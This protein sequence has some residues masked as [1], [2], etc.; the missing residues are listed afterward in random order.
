MFFRRK[1]LKH[2]L[3]TISTRQSDA[4]IWLYQF[5]CNTLLISLFFFLHLDPNTVSES[6]SPNRGDLPSRMSC[7]CHSF[8]ISDQ[9]QTILTEL[10]TQSYAIA[11]IVWE[12]CGISIAQKPVLSMFYDH[13]IHTIRSILELFHFECFL[14]LIILAQNFPQVTAQPLSLLGLL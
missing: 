7:W 12:H 2:I 13:I 8:K 3:V 9:L 4:V 1:C 5:H 10:N 6:S 11:L 14:L